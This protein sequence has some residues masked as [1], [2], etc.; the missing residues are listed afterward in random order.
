[1][2]KLL[3]LYLILGAALVLG[4]CSNSYSKRYIF[5]G[6]SDHWEAKY[7]YNTTESK[8]SQNSQES[9]ELIL[10]YKKSI[11]DLSSMKELEFSLNSNGIDDKV[12]KHFK[13]PS[14]EKTFSFRGES[15][16][17]YWI[18]EDESIKVNVKWDGMEESFDLES[19]SK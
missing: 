8:N 13:E 16:G 1:M 18:G 3:K 11:E 6:E 10:T 7:I 14:K 9:Y 12:K 2:S 17:S 19:A 4:A 5:T 15:K